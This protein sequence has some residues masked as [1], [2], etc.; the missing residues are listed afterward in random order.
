M[1]TNENHIVLVWCE[2]ELNMSINSSSFCLA[3]KVRVS[4][5]SGVNLNYYLNYSW[6]HLT[7]EDLRVIWCEFELFD[8]AFSSPPWGSVSQNLQS[9]FN[10]ANQPSWKRQKL[11]AKN[12]HF[13]L[14]CSPSLLVGRPTRW[15]LL[16]TFGFLIWSY[17]PIQITEKYSIVLC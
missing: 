10:L 11:R 4:S 8:K 7:V 5:G 13:F 1:L 3:L 16:F 9:C 6:F 12:L 15:S 2:F 17:F 14:H